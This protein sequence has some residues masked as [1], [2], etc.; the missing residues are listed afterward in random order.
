LAPQRTF[1]DNLFKTPIYNNT[2]KTKEEL[3]TEF[4]IRRGNNQSIYN[5]YFINKQ[6]LIHQ[7]YNV[8]SV[9]TT[10]FY[11]MHLSSNKYSK[12]QLHGLFLC[13]YEASYS[14]EAFLIP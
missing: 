2:L 13:Y 4:I 9:L 14:F 11:K 6:E 5:M 7:D 12:D 3:Y 1:I 10:N 8:N